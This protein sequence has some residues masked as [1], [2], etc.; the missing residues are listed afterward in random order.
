MYSGP[1]KGRIDDF[2]LP[3]SPGKR[4]NSNISASSVP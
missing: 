4:K 1:A 2:R 3:S